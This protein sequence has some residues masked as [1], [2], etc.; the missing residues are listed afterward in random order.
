MHSYGLMGL[1]PNGRPA[2]CR[3]GGNI[4]V[5]C[6]QVRGP[7]L[8]GLAAPGGAPHCLLADTATRSYTSSEQASC[9][10]SWAKN[11]TSAVIWLR[12][13]AVL[14]MVVGAGRQLLGTGVTLH[15]ACPGFVNTPMI[16]D[17][18]AAAVRT[19]QSRSLSQPWL[20]CG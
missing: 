5:L 15:M 12:R 20:L 6:V 11:I 8:H 18:Q 4:R 3:R 14:L 17:A 7:R 19:P 1:S 13:C 10:R 16:R 2:A 9:I